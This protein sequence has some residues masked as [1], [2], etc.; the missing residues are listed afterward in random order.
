ME[1]YTGL[2]SCPSPERSS[3]VTIGVYDGVHR[4]HRSII[5]E[6]RKVA[7]ERK[8]RSGVVTFDPHPARIVRPESAPLLLTDITQRLELLDETGIDSALVVA[9]DEERAQESAETFVVQ[10]LV[11]CMRAELVVIGADFHFGRDREGNTERLTVMGT[12]HGFETVVMP[13]VDIDGDPASENPQVSSTA[14]R[15]ALHSGDLET[16]NRLLGRPF[17]IRGTVA[18]GDGR[19]RKI[20]FPT[21]NIAI[22]EN[23]A[24]PANGVYAGWYERP[25]GDIHP[26]VA[27]IGTRP[28]FDVTTDEVVIECHLLDYESDMYSETA[29][30]RFTERLRT[31]MV[32]DGADALRKAIG[33]DIQTARKSLGI[34]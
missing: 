7:A 2:D 22:D 30:V 26:M 8:L 19:G 24:V 29:K 9:F 1:I 23:L 25:D 3:A 31:E 13:L 4:G 14:I 16:A 11:E 12:E 33:A 10:T 32:F 20:G 17:E 18:K 21:A 34:A 6:L 5:R 15:A 28:T 27:N